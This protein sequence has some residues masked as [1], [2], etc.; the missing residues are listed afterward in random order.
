MACWTRILLLVE[1]VLSYGKVEGVISTAKGP[2]SALRGCCVIVATSILK[3]KC[4]PL[5][6]PACWI[7]FLPS[8][9]D[10]HLR[11]VLHSSPWLI[12][13]FVGTASLLWAHRGAWWCRL[14]KFWATA[15]CTIQWSKLYLLALVYCAQ[16]ISWRYLF[17]SSDSRSIRQCP[18][19]APDKN[20]CNVAYIA[21]SSCLTHDELRSNMSATLPPLNELSI[22]FKIAWRHKAIQEFKSQQTSL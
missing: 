19:V 14:S 20:V 10:L 7:L 5:K 18:G 15:Y 13:N 21:R 9:R 3:K 2:L 1:S 12:M 6:K 4:M 8:P 17:H 22:R 11:C 16:S